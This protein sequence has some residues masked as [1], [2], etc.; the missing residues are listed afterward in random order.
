M[1][2]VVI[3]RAAG[4]GILPRMVRFCTQCS[5]VSLTHPSPQLPAPTAPAPV[6]SGLCTVSVGGDWASRAHMP[7][8]QMCLSQM[9]KDSDEQP[10]YSRAI[11]HN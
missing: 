9:R 3:Q 5:D 4:P 10:H 11:A 8:A 7:I 6:V 1:T 2:H